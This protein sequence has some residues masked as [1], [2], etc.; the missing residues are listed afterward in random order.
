MINT[1]LRNAHSNKY[2]KGMASLLVSISILSIILAG[3]LVVLFMS[4]ASQKTAALDMRANQAFDAAQ[5]GLNIATV[6]INENYKTVTDTNSSGQI[7]YTMGPSTLPNGA[8]YTATLTNL[9]LNVYDTFSLVSIG[10]SGDGSI[11]RTIYNTIFFDD[12][13]TLGGPPV[14]L[15]A[16]GEV[17]LSGNISIQNP[18]TTTT[19][20]SGGDVGLSGAADTENSDGEGSDRNT[21]GA[22]L[23]TNDGQLSTISEANFF[24]TF[25]G[26]AKSTVKT[27]AT[28]SLA[29]TGDHNYSNELNGLEGQMIWIEQDGGSARINGGT[30]GSVDNPVTLIISGTGEFKLNGNATIYGIVYV[31]FDWDNDGGGNAEIHGSAISNGEMDFNGVPNLFYVQHD[32]MF[33]GG[34]TANFA[35]VAGSWRDFQ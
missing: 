14:P 12:G 22:D 2:Q 21:Q 9:T 4:I 6:F 20:W 27:M 1:Y 5:S 29:N 32:S 31:D 19:I 11:T 18:L 26:K 24:K 8:S 13:A 3:S 16:R 30:I 28:T 7:I 35:S 10:T 34:Q 15:L 33:L 17:S 23:T 25:F